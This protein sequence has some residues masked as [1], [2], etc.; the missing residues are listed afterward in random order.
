[1]SPRPRR[2][3]LYL[4]ASNARALAK[5]RTL[6]VDAV[7]LDLEDAVAPDA[8]RAARQAACAAVAEG[9][10][11]HRELCVRVNALGTPWHDDD[12]TA[13][14]AARPDAVVVPKVDSVAEVH[15]LARALGADGPDLW[16]MIE[17]PRGVVAAHDIAGA[18]ERLT[19][20]VLGTNDLVKEL[21][22]QH[23]PG[24]APVLH[25]LSHV[26]LAA[27][28]HGIDVLDGVY[29]DVTDADGFAAECRQAW[30]MGF[31][32]KTLIHPSQV[33]TANAQWAPSPEQVAEATELITTYEAAL[34]EGKGVVTHRGRMIENLHVE[35]ARRMLALAEAIRR[36]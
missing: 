36:E 32:G 22:A 13:V 16:A 11:G 19:C 15:A 23:V 31:D 18:S 35:T 5:A 14:V 34:A 21:G 27:R 26:V 9:G 3:V 1:M 10:F 4:P 8:K 17:T 30:E 28:A 7:I 6:D 29:N 20:L 2:S 24:R 12:M 25:V 33:A